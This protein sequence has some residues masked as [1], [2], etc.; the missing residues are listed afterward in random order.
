M[1]RHGE[2][3]LGPV[4]YLDCIVFCVFLAPQLVL[5]AGFFETVWCALKALPF[6]LAKLPA[7]VIHDRYLIPREERSVFQRRASA[8]EDIV[9]RCMR[10]AFVNIPPRVGRVFFSREVSLPFLWF[11]LLRH[12]YPEPPIHWREHCESGLRGI[13]LIK[14]PERRPDFALYYAHGGGFSM[15]S[16]YFY[17][18]YLLT[19]LSTLSSAGYGN[20]AIFALEYTLVPECSFPTQVQ[21]TLKGYEYVLRM[22]QDPSIICVSGDSAGATLILCLLLH[23]GD[24]RAN[25]LGEKQPLAGFPRAKPALA[26]L[27]SPWVTLISTRHKNTTSDYLDVKQLRRYGAQ[28]AGGRISEADPL[29]SPGCCKDIEWWKRSSPSTGFVIMYGTEEVLAPEIEYLVEILR[30]AKVVVESKAELGGIHAWPV[31]SLFL[32]G[33]RD[34]RREGLVTMTN[35]IRQRIS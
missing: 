22:V 20:P 18:E 23:L 26:V 11:R 2:L 3:N 5:Q 28:F 29:V 13:W 33:S 17:L 31:A 35:E 32:S 34:G 1:Q 10:Y 6:L 27:I 15:G 4:S 14:D 16:S 19:W 30:E 24:E 12:G 9:V 8:F 7:A 21:E 25:A